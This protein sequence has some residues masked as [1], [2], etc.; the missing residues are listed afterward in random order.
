MTN[1]SATVGMRRCEAEGSQNEESREA[2]ASDRATRV[3][4]QFC[5]SR[6]RSAFKFGAGR[7][8]NKR[9]T[10]RWRTVAR[11]WGYVREERARRLVGRLGCKKR[12]QGNGEGFLAK[13]GKTAN[14]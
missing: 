2:V 9:T 8:D 7:G 5:V 10:A 12:T 3:L 14:V 13:W 1:S 6:K 11:R 4:A